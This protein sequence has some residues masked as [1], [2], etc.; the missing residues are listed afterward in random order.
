[1]LDVDTRGRRST[2][3]RGGRGRAAGRGRPQHAAEN[4]PHVSNVLPLLCSGTSFS[5]PGPPPTQEPVST[6]RTVPSIPFT[7]SLSSPTTECAPHPPPLSA[8][9]LR[10]FSASRRLPPR[11]RRARLERLSAT[12]KRGPKEA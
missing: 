6:P 2:G 9:C 8:A 4:S 11:E 3:G 10:L 12:I 1:M 5:R 7:F